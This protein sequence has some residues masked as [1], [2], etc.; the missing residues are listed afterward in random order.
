MAT[1]FRILDYNY[2]FQSNVD[3]TA[4]SSNASFPVTNLSEYIRAK[5][6]R[7]SGN[8]VIDSTNNK[9]DYKESGGGSEI[10]A[11]L[12]SGSYTSSTLAAEIKTRMEAASL[13]ARTYT[14]TYSQLTGKFT[15]AGQTFLSLLFLTGTNNAT[16]TKTILGFSAFDYIGSTSY[17]SSFI[18][19][20]SFET[21]DID[22]KSNEEIDTFAIFFDPVIGVQLS[23]NAV[24]KIQANATPYWVNPAVNVTLSFDEE[25][26]VL[27]YF[28]ATSQEYRYWRIYIED[29][30]NT[31]FY[32]ELGTVFLGKA[33]QLSKIPDNGF[34]FTQEDRSLITENEYGHQYVDIYPIRKTIVFNY[35]VLPYS[36][37][38]TLDTMFKRIGIH[39]PIMVTMDAT[40]T[41]FDKD[42]FTIYGR[43]DKKYIQ[44]HQ[45]VNFY[46][47]D[48]TV[49]ETL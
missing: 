4:S 18:S 32:I 36:D 33:T 30:K 1:E 45:T 14:I 31:D 43:F 28:W 40:E 12:T 19:I 42:Q 29:P 47:T 37:I 25:R 23:S 9:I 2:I 38:A 22:L 20:H 17:V 21:I 11:T 15:I 10:T 34:T 41:Q 35:S 26:D 27:T 13:N 46:K 39:T 8:F 3:I 48:L 6:W 44:Q 49:V 24:I 7:S 16:S 5:S